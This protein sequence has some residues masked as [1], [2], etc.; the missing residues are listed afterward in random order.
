[1]FKLNNFTTRE[2]SI[3]SI[4]E[5]SAGEGIWVFKSEQEGEEK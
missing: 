2:A 1:M 5:Q 4:W 3:D